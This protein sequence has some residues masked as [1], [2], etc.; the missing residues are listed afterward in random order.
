[1]AKHQEHYI[2]LL[3]FFFLNTVDSYLSAGF[4]NANFGR[5]CKVWLW[6]EHENELN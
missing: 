4:H 3:N 5:Q 1:M 6:K 2:S